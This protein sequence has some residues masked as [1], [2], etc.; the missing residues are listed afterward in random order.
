MAILSPKHLIRRSSLSLLL[1]ALVSTL[2]A[3]DIPHMDTLIKKYPK[4]AAVFLKKSTLIDFSVKKDSLIILSEEF[5]DRMYIKDNVTF[6]SEDRVQYSAFDQLKSIKAATLTPTKNSYKETPVT[7]FITNELKSSSVFHDDSKEMKFTYNNLFKGCRTVSNVSFS[8]TEPH[9]LSFYFLQSYLPA[10]EVV[11]KIIADNTVDIG[12]IVYNEKLLPIKFEKNVGKKRTEYIWTV[13]SA[14]KLEFESQAPNLRYLYTHIIPYVKTYE[15]S[16]GTKKIFGD[17][18][19]LFTWYKSLT[20]KVDYNK[21]DADLKKTMTEIL[22]NTEINTDTEKAKSFFYWVQDNIKYVAFEEK[23]EGFIPRNAD[24]VHARKYG[25]CK[26]MAYML[27][28][29]MKVEGLKGYPVWIGTRDIPYTYAEVPLPVSDNHMI[30]AFKDGQ[31]TIFLDAT[32]SYLPYGYPSSFIQGKEGLIDLG[33]GNF[34]IEKVPIMPADATSK[35]DTVWL[36]QDNNILKGKGKLYI[37]GY[38]RSDF[39][40]AING[41]QE[42]DKEKMIKSITLKGNN[43]YSLDSYTLSNLD[44]KDLPIII[45]YNFSLEDYIVSAQEK[46]YINLNLDDDYRYSNIEEDTKNPLEFNYNNQIIRTYIFDIPAEKEITFIPADASYSHDMFDFKTH[47]QKTDKNIL[48]QTEFKLKTLL[49]PVSE[50]EAW[51]KYIKTIKKAQ[52]EVISIH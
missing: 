27:T 1:C 31:K 51:N 20:Q 50:F 12:Y 47:Y 7:E 32:N 37:N 10:E 15:T 24:K 16:Q 39:A 14:P 52:S 29:M 22:S 43:K 13:S 38:M 25:D 3:Q 44:N 18:D 45:E 49:L 9:L 34:Q 35:I 23:Y 21:C 6:L 42:D 48:L 4:D 17:V 5:E 33:D 26:D 28:T 46:S 8:H 11:F 30:S 2:V 40:H 19:A 41:L 36:H